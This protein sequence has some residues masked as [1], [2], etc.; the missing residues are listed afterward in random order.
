M[1]DLIVVACPDCTNKSA[2]RLKSAARSKDSHEMLQSNSNHKSLQDF[3]KIFARHLNSS[4]S[5]HCHKVTSSRVT[6]AG[7]AQQ[8]HCR[9]RD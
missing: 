3:F 2:I 5:G 4:A 8:N 7:Y 1:G 6:I 9:Q